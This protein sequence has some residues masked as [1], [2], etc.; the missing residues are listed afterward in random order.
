MEDCCGVRAVADVGRVLLP[1]SHPCHLPS[2]QWAVG[3]MN[4]TYIVVACFK[5]SLFNHTVSALPARLVEEGL[6]SHM[7]SAAA[8][9]FAA[10]AAAKV[11]L[12]S[13]S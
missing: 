7:C 8:S 6:P 13:M 2:P 12:T 10:A 1:L 9:S 4:P 3:R 11:L 5:T